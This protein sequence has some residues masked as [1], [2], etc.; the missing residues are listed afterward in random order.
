MLYVDLAIG[1]FPKWLS[2]III[3][4]E[5]VWSRWRPCTISTWSPFILQT[6]RPTG[7]DDK[8]II[9]MTYFCRL[10]LTAVSGVLLVSIVISLYS[11][12]ATDSVS[13][14]HI[15]RASRQKPAVDHARSSTRST[16]LRITPLYTRIMHCKPCWK[17]QK[18]WDFAEK[19]IIPGSVGEGLKR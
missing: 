7:N 6:N 5:C 11:S 1:P 16:L 18:N 15:T 10:S 13:R 3:V 12:V 8:F 2:T 14:L 9:F 19:L 4:P 17:R